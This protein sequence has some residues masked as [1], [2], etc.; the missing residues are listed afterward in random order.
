VTIAAGFRFDNGLLLCADTQYTAGHK[1][2]ESKMFPIAH[3]NASL[4]LVLTG[5]DVYGPRTVEMIT[6]E[7]KRVSLDKL[8]KEY[9]HNA[10]EAGL[11]RM[12][13]G[14]IYPHPDWGKETCP[15]VQFIIG[16]HSP[17]DGN[18]LMKTANDTAAVVDEKACLGTGGVLG[19]Y[20]TRMYLGPKQS[21]SQIVAFATYLLHEVKTH[22][23]YCGGQ[24]EFRVLGNDGKIS[25]VE[26]QDIVLA[27]EYAPAFNKAVSKTFY[28]LADP[29]KDDDE[30]HQEMIEA[31][32]ELFSS[33][34]SR[35]DRRAYTKVAETL[36]RWLKEGKAFN[37]DSK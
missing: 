18:Y 4:V 13:D 2:Y 37:D 11:R 28:A 20:L 27:E 22:D 21:L 34:I 25:P 15:E 19:D 35:K 5:W 9:M 36:E 3:G 14:H 30:M 10:I 1:T 16:M 6:E 31:D 7:I 24:S 12:F 26:L 8:T 29:D 23:A 32:Q 33:L 17:V